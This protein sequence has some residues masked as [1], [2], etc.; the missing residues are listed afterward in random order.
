M[1]PA[2]PSRG[3]RRLR[4]R[5]QAWLIALACFLCGAG[6]AYRELYHSAS[7][8]SL[9]LP[10]HPAP[11]HADPDP[12]G[13]WLL[14]D[15]PADRRPAF[16]ADGIRAAFVI[17]VGP[18][19]TE[20]LADTLKNLHK[21]VLAHR[22]RPVLLFTPGDVPANETAALRTRLPRAVAAA[23]KVVPL[24][25][26]TRM[27]HEFRGLDIEN[28][29]GKQDDTWVRRY[30]AYHNM[31]RRATSCFLFPAQLPPCPDGAAV[32]RQRRAMLCCWS[33]W[34][35]RAP[36]EQGACASRC[37]TRRSRL[38]GPVQ[39]SFQDAAAMAA[40]LA[41]AEGPPVGPRPAAEPSVC[42]PSQVEFDRHPGQPGDAGPGLLL[43]PGHA[44]QHIVQRLR[45]H[46]RPHGRARPA[47]RLRRQVM[48]VLAITCH[49]VDERRASRNGCVM[50]LRA[51]PMPRGS[52]LR[53]QPLPCLLAQ[54][55][56]TTDG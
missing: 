33:W 55:H 16:D 42:M 41:K 48:I 21:H 43:P 15:V 8:A 10:N 20:E 37:S 9:S 53:H 26:F 44:F 50:R 45:R 40:V 19:T 24:P 38:W 32:H 29:A 51:L 17:L 7:T 13:A 25:D 34:V 11:Q 47:L 6:Y 31:C 27:P 14:P 28:V 49:K 4:S 2:K 46:V 22:P 52:K 1:H 18:N 23:V 56:L 39:C 54:R 35:V 3:H 30:P 12:S 5:R 36:G